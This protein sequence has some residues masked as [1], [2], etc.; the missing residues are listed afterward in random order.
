MFE[1]QQLHRSRRWLASTIATLCLTACGGGANTPSNEPTPTGKDATVITPTVNQER[2][3]ATT[4]SDRDAVARKSINK[5]IIIDTQTNQAIKT[6][7][8]DG[9]SSQTTEMI[10]GYEI[11]LDQ[12]AFSLKGQR[13]VYY[14]K[15]GKVFRQDLNQSDLPEPK[16]ISNLQNA[17]GIQ[18]SNTLSPSNEVIEIITRGQN[19]TCDQSSDGSIKQIETTMTASDP[20]LPSNKKVVEGIYSAANSS[21][22]PT[23]MLV[24]DKVQNKLFAYSNNL[25]NQLYEIRTPA[26]VLEV[27]AQIETSI[28]PK[29]G[30]QLLRIDQELFATTM[31]N[32][33]LTIDS[34]VTSATGET[35]VTELISTIDKTFVLFSDNSLEQFISPSQG[36]RH[37]ANLPAGTGPLGD[38]SL[39][40][41]DLVFEAVSNT[42]S[43]STSTY[44]KVDTTQK[45]VQILGSFL[46]GSSD[47]PMSRE[48]E[49]LWVIQKS[50]GT[51]GPQKLVKISLKTGASQTLLAGIIQVGAQMSIKLRS[52]S[53]DSFVYCRPQPSRTD[54]AG[55]MLFSR[56]MTTGAEVGI[57]SYQAETGSV[58]S[59]AHIDDPWANGSYGV[60]NIWNQTSNS[61]T[62]STVW[63]YNPKQANSL[64]KLTLPN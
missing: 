30:Y 17:C 48:G 52:M 2:F 39:E 27:N 28:E 4:I 12:L 29:T 5:L 59:N 38:W 58:S 31:I 7:T 19:N 23:A 26:N 55:A 20:S 45:S 54:C 56:D 49:Y 10:Y 35:A 21:L 61:A 32:G 14:I 11:N 33:Q 37:I 1:S 18:G 36:T 50:S 64:T 34:Q 9:S 60:L 22:T 51:D 3:R 46:E 40:G 42:P 44:Y 8:L 43:N 6:I 41:E 47:Y 24:H 25:Q 63:A 15:D 62:H 16:Q 13:A 57:G 53:F